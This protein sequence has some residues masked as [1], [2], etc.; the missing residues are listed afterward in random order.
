MEL[1]KEIEQEL[2]ELSPY[3]AALSRVHPFIVPKDYF[4]QLEKETINSLNGGLV[5]SIYEK[6]TMTTEHPFEVPEEYFESLSSNIL[7]R[8]QSGEGQNTEVKLSPVKRARPV[9]FKVWLAAA[10]VAIIAMSSIIFFNRSIKDSAESQQAQIAITDSGN[11]SLLENASDIDEA[12]IMNLL[13]EQRGQQQG[14]NNSVSDGNQTSDDNS[15]LDATDIDLD[16]ID[17]I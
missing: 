17:E 8:I 13:V 12:T 14:N 9:Q 6:D 3:L 11:T 10:S 2:R 4:L 15:L 16:L 5:R 7:N 1:R